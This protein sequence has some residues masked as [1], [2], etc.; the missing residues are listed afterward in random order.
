MRWIYRLLKRAS[1][2][3][4]ALLLLEITSPAQEQRITRPYFAA[5]QQLALSPC[6]V[7]YS[8]DLRTCDG[9]CADCDCLPGFKCCCR[10]PQGYYSLGD[11]A[12]KCPGGTYQDEFAAGFCKPCPGGSGETYIV[13]STRVPSTSTIVPSTAAKC[14]LSQCTAAQAG[15]TNNLCQAPDDIVAS[16]SAPTVLVEWCQ[17]HLALPSMDRSG[18][19]NLCV[20]RQFSSDA[21]R[22]LSLSTSG[23][24]IVTAMLLLRFGFG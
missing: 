20:F 11:R 24:V 14:K 23:V 5:A 17:T 7:G 3:Q 16:F 15:A 10:T 12:L 9:V 19:R 2:G 1:V 13:A 8:R 4:Q 6:R 22:R 18:L 21:S